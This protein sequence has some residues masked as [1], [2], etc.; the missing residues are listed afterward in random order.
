MTV[1]KYHY[2]YQITNIEE[3]KHYI[4]KRSCY[5]LPEKD[6][7]KQY[8][9]SS[10]CKQFI[11]DQKLNPSKFIYKIF[12]IF[13]TKKEAIT[14]ESY[15]HKLYNVWHNL[16]YYN[17]FNDKV[18]NENFIT[19]YKTMK[20]INTTP[21]IKRSS[22]DVNQELR[23]KTVLNK[24]IEKEKSI[25]RTKEEKLKLKQKLK[26]EKLKEKLEIQRKKEETQQQ[27]RNEK[28]KE[29]QKLKEEKQKLKQKLKEEKLKEITKLNSINTIWT[30]M[31]PTQGI[32]RCSRLD[33]RNK[34]PHI[35]PLELFEFISDIYLN[36]TTTTLYGWNLII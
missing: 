32:Y 36:K 35:T 16:E 4:G 19:C 26:E 1:F 31:H 30:F 3:N 21:T 33:F 7:G 12:Q 6:L 2:T 34:F 5:I 11:E 9:S 10:T 28:L 23:E 17:R 25:Q 27:K 8:F 22:I 20:N 18:L 24:K 29:K 14:H 15:L 13:D